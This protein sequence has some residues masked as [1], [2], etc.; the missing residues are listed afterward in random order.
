MPVHFID[1]P[2]L[3]ARAQELSFRRAS[4]Q[5]ILAGLRMAETLTG[6]AMTSPA[7]IVWLDTLTAMSAWVTGD[8]VDGVFLTAPLSA[9]G[10]EAVRA[11]TFNPGWPALDHICCEGE[12]CGGVYIG[13]YAGETK[14]TRRRVVM[15]AGIIRHEFFAPVPCFAR[16]ATEDG[17][18]SMARLGFQPIPG[19][20][21]DLWGQEP[22]AG[23]EGRAA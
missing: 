2:A 4:Y 1:Y 17:A 11:G 5:E 7:T 18:R 23:A 12:A 10:A 6:Q 16:A 9:A 14:E 13:V 22:V 8:P 20:L 19:G 21:P 3:S 15:A